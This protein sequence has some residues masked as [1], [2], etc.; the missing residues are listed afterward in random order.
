MESLSQLA[1]DCPWSPSVSELS[2]GVQSFDGNRTM[3]RC[4]KSL[5]KRFKGK[6]NAKDFCF[7]LD[8]TANPK[9]GKNTFRGGYW[10]GADGIMYG[11]KIVM[12]A[13]V[14]MKTKVAY[15]IGY[16]FAIKKS[17]IDYKKIPEI[18]LDLIRTAI[19]DGYPKL[20]IAVD[21]W[22]D[23]ADFINAVKDLGL[24]LIGQFKSNRTVKVGIATNSKWINI[25]KFFNP[26]LRSSFRAHPFGSKKDKKLKWFSEKNIF[27][28]KVKSR[29]KAIAVYNRK[30]GVGAFGYYF[31]TDLSLTG[32]QVWKYCR[33]RWYIECLFRDLKQ[34]L[35]FGKLSCQGENAANLAVCFPLILYIS[36]NLDFKKVWKLKSFEST[37][38]AIRAIM[39]REWRRS[40]DE[41]RKNPSSELVSKYRSR[42][43]DKR[44]ARKPID[45]AVEK[46]NALKR[47]VGL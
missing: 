18:A 21:S 42:N 35:S 32:V 37:G 14:N 9:Y 16:S 2:R 8:D 22:F 3:R 29:V 24:T 41:I 30:N 38:S 15:P 25:K 13:L 47:V 23:G 6:L 20:P 10:R 28:K 33:A 43:H 12:L 44:L 31:T 5:L 27:I 1:R 40:V 36:L 39:Q 34:N 11:Q 17:E 46:S 26:L 7:A 19:S 45:S 4:R